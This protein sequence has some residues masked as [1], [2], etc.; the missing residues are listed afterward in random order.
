MTFKGYIRR[1]Y[2]LHIETKIHTEPLIQYVCSSIKY[3]FTCPFF[4]SADCLLCKEPVAYTQPC[5]VFLLSE[6][7]AN[8]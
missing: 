2:V 7:T 5:T 1:V 3:P 6:N 8:K 4:G